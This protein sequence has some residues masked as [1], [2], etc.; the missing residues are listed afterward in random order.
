[1]G[2]LILLLS[3]RRN[4]GT[5]PLKKLLITLIKSVAALIPVYFFNTLFVRYTGTW[6]EQGSTFQNLLRVLL[7][8]LVDISVVLI[9]YRL[10]KVE[11]V[12][13]L[14]SSLRRRKQP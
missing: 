7:L 1:V 4:T 12:S 9:M 13:V 8:A 5:L 11:M 6:W 2:L 10:L 14:L 3:A